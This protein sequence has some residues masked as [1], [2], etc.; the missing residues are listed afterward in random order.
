MYEV[1]HYPKYYFCKRG[2]SDRSWIFSRIK[3][4]PEHRQ[5]EVADN[6][7][8]IYLT[9]PINARRKANEYLNNVAREYNDSRARNAKR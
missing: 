2:H 1:K 4:I 9:T 7:E 3:H 6:Y 5:Q 8:H